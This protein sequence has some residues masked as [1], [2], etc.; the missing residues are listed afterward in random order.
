MK[1]PLVFLL[2]LAAGRAPCGVQEQTREKAPVV[3]TPANVQVSLTTVTPNEIHLGQKPGQATVT[4]QIHHQLIPQGQT[5]TVDLEVATYS[6][7][8]P[9]GV[10]ASYSPSLQQAAMSG[11]PGV[12][13]ETV[14]LS[15]VSCP[16]GFFTCTIVVLASLANASSGL[17]ILQPD[18]VTD[19]RATLTVY[20]QQ[21][22]QRH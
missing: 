22:G 5:Q 17:T 11:A 13:V 8:P 1:A 3:P 7:T 6:T 9:K 19:A 21:P 2:V 20:S 12:A 14:E 16:T 4:V 15:R 18:P 10:G